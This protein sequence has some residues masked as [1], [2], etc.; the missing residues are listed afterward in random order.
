MLGLQNTL[1]ACLLVGA[2]SGGLSGWYFYSDG[3]GDERTEWLERERQRTDAAAETAR[4]HAAA[5]TVRAAASER[6]AVA[7]V[8]RVQEVKREVV[9]L[10]RPDCEWADDERVRLQ[11]VWRAYFDAGEPAGG[12]PRGLRSAAVS[13]GVAD[14]VG[15]ADAGLGLRLPPPRE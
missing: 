15:G 11:S 13:L 14:G 12:L 9:Y 8:A 4:L 2:F 10:P 6:R 3:R 1:L 7:T 5:Q